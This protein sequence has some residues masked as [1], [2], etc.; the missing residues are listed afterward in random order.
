MKI[1]QESVPLTTDSSRELSVENASTGMKVWGENTN[2]Y[3]TDLHFHF[4][5]YE[6]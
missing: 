3:I 5:R 1:N 4:I 2:L 6:N